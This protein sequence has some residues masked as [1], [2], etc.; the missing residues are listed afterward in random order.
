MER[1]Q[2]RSTKIA[3]F[4]L[5]LVTA[6]G[7]WFYADTFGNGGSA[8][9]ARQEITGI[10]IEYTGEE[11]LVEQDLMLLS[12]GTS[13]T[14]DLTFIGSRLLVCQLDRAHIRVTAD[15]SGIQSPGAQTV[16]YSWT[17]LDSQYKATLPARQKYSRLTVERK[18]ESASVNVSELNSKEVDVRCELVGTV[19]KG[20][21]AGQIQLSQSSIEI[22]GLEADLEA[23]SYAKISLDLGRDAKETVSALLE[24]G[25]YDQSNQ[26]IEDGGFRPVTDKIQATLPIYVTRDLALVIDFTDAPGIRLADADYRILPDTVTVMGEARYLDGVESLTIGE[27]NLQNLSGQGKTPSSHTFP[28]VVP[29]GCENLSGVNRATLRISFPNLNTA[30][31]T[32]TRFAIHT[33]LPEGKTAEVLTDSLDVALYGTAEALGAVSGGDLLVIPDLSGYT[34]AAG[35]YTVPADVEVTSGADVGVSG[36]DY[37]VRVRILE[38]TGE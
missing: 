15:L 6:M 9:S 13:S 24:C 36:D 38:E 27:F 29:E 17:F 23:V 11:S 10:P 7:I 35:D 32:T 33:E 18:V 26:L 30:T 3:Y 4:L 22:R 21:S 19:A 1:N 28:V 34:A 8:F 12:D 25:F 16:S 37:Q 14:V 5:A 20:Y 31:V 2:E